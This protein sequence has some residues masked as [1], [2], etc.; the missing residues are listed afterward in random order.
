M[1]MDIQTASFLVAALG[2]FLGAASFAWQVLHYVLTGGRIRVR[3]RLGFM[4]ADEST[5]VTQDPKAFTEAQVQRLADQG[6]VHRLAVVEVVNKGRMPVTVQRWGV[7]AS[8]GASIHPIGDSIGPQLPHRL[9]VGE[10]ATWAV[11]WNS[12]FAL[13]EASK[14]LSDG[15]P[16]RLRGVAE[17]AD[18][19]PKKS[20][21]Y[22]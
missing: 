12:A 4:G 7:R 21:E 14:A 20:R 22:L 16:V 17:L 8:P 10:S 15:R 1:N 2:G 19:R 6:F 9:D 18:G 5:L 3:L 13:R 11:A